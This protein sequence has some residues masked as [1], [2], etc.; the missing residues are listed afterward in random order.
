VQSAVKRLP[1]TEK[2]LQSRE[3][4]TTSRVNCSG[5]ILCKVDG[6]RRKQDLMCIVPEEKE[7]RKST[8][9]LCHGEIILK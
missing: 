5:R 1:L 2:V 6:L 3:C 9:V 7:L 8:V 4:R